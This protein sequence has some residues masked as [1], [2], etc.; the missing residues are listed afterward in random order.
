[1]EGACP[2][3]NCCALGSVSAAVLLHDSLLAFLWKP[4]DLF[5]F[6]FFAPVPTKG[7]AITGIQDLNRC[8]ELLVK[9]PAIP[10]SASYLYMH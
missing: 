10:S 2:E 4:D 1:M 7:T 6:F 3:K 9:K 8:C 5:F